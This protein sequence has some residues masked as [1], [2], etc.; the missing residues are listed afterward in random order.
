MTLNK[1]YFDVGEEVRDLTIVGGGPTGIFAAFQ[2]GM[3]NISC[4]IIDDLL[5]INRI[6]SGM[7]HLDIKAV[8]PSH[9]GIE[10]LESC[11]FPARDLL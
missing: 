2:C 1:L 6:E 4:R 7:A 5:D 10:G 9:L 11:L 8:S 3:N